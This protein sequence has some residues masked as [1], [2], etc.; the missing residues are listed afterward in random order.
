MSEFNKTIGL[1]RLINT[2]SY[3]KD[4]FRVALR[5]PAVFQLLWLHIPLILLA[6]WCDFTL[7]VKMVLVLASFLSVILEFF[8]TALEAAVDHTS[9]EI[10]PLAKIAKDVGSSAQAL[11]LIMVAVLWGMAVF[12]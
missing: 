8:N 3:S 5:E 11:T 9:M 6:L 2:L 1:K 12:A 7:A 4:G 10:H